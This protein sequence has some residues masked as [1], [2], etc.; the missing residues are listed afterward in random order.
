MRTKPG[1][2]I[3]FVRI[4]GEARIGKEIACRPLPHIANHLAAPEDRI[5]IWVTAGITTAVCRP[6]EIG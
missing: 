4:F 2:R 5:A 1:A 6:V 3:F